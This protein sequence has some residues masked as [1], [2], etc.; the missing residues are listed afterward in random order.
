MLEKRFQLLDGQHTW[1][2][3]VPVLGM[4]N[5]RDEGGLFHSL[6][7]DLLAKQSLHTYIRHVNQRDI[8][9]DAVIYDPRIPLR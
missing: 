5:V 3:P 2:G 8:T 4:I 6:S 1:G 9:S 7:L